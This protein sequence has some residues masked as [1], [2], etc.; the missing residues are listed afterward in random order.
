MVRVC[1]VII[2]PGVFFH[3]FKTLILW[4]VSGEKGQKMAQ[5]VKKIISVTL[6]MSGTI[7]HV[8]AIYGTLV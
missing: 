8:I 1:Q 7:D 2:C 6:H 4:V 3:S 5:N